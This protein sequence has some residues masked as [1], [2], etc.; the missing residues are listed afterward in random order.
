MV[1]IS[2]EAN[3]KYRKFMEDEHVILDSFGETNSSGYFAVF[4]GHSLA[5]GTETVKYVSK[6]MHLELIKDMETCE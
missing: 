3:L 6:N 1:G 2:T 4:D 5:G